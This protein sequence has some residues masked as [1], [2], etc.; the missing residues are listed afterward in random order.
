MTGFFQNIHRCTDTGA[1]MWKTDVSTIQTVSLP[2]IEAM[3]SRPPQ[4][5]QAVP[6]DLSKIL[7]T[8]HGYPFV[9]F[10]GHFV[11]YLLRPN[12]ELQKYIDTKKE[13]LKFKTPLVGYVFSPCML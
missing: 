6:R 9:W 12:P 8:F 7:V 5:P 2:N 4:L 3:S 13:E 10:A 1:H 11:K